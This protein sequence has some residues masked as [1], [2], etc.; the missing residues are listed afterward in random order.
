M[1]KIF[2]FSALFSFLVNFSFFNPAIF[3]GESAS[4]R[5]FEPIKLTQYQGNGFATLS[6]SRY[7]T[8]TDANINCDSASCKQFL[9]NRSNQLK[10]TPCPSCTPPSSCTCTT[11]CPQEFQVMD[12]FSSPPSMRGSIAIPRGYRNIAKVLFTWTVRVEGLG[13]PETIFPGICGKPYHG[14]TVQ[15]FGGQVQTQLYVKRPNDTLYKAVGDIVQ[16]SMPLSSQAIAQYNDPTISGS[17]LLTGDDF[18]TQT[19]VRSALPAT[20]DFELRWLNDSS[21]DIRSPANQ[22][23]LTATLLPIEEE[24]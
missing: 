11:L 7:P 2:F 12:I 21:Y 14:T 22:Y 5:K 13:T 1:K 18:V 24:D 4:V 17:Y 23:Q 3:A 19:T 6:A 15:Q 9:L 16:L 8:Y 20:V 10:C